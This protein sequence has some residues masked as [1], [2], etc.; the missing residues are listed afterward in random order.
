MPIVPY[1]NVTHAIPT[2]IVMKQ[3][4]ISYHDDNDDENDDENDDAARYV[5]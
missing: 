1:D 3:T 5:S 2:C 4:I